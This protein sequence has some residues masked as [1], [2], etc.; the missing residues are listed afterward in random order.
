MDYSYK[1]KV[2]IVGAGLAGCTMARI[3]AENSIKVFKSFC[4]YL[5]LIDRSVLFKAKQMP[6]LIFLFKNREN[7]ID[8]NQL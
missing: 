7:L 2:L 1:K 5:P 3:F 4:R 8:F 6:T